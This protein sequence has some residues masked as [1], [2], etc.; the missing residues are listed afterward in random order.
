MCVCLS[1]FELVGCV[2]VTL[3]LRHDHFRYIFYNN[4]LLS[5]STKHLAKV[6]D[7]LLFTIIHEHCSVYTFSKDFFMIKLGDTVE[8][9]FHGHWQY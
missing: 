9:I 5:N 7:F 6:I 3:R 4:S 2:T 8:P 1:H